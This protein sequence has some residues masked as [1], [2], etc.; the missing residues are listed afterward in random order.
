LFSSKLLPELIETVG[1]TQIKA[2]SRKGTQLIPELLSVKAAAW[3]FGLS[4]LEEFFSVFRQQ[5]VMM[6]PWYLEVRI[7]T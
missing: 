2:E 5:S 7:S 4:C 6:K 1:Q 3:E